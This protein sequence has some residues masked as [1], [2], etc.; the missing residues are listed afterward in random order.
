MSK[1]RGNCEKCGKQYYG[2]GIRFCSVDCSGSSKRA[3]NI[4]K[5]CGK[6]YMGRSLQF[7]STK[8]SA[9]YR[10]TACLVG[11]S[12]KDRLYPLLEMHDL[13]GCWNYCGV[14]DNLELLWRKR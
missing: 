11:N 6:S 5:N 13:F 7:C 4:C 14:K 12:L 9:I 2:Y 1:Y 10:R 3:V 8:C